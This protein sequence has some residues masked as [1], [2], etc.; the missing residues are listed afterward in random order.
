MLR[1]EVPP[2]EMKAQR[3]E[4]TFECFLEIFDTHLRYCMDFLA[5]VPENKQEPELGEWIDDRI[6]FDMYAYKEH[7]S[8]LELTEIAASKCWAIHVL[9]SGFAS[10]IGIYVKS[11]RE[12]EKIRDAIHT[13]RHTP[14]YAVKTN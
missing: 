6:Q 5:Q 2:L 9:V 3:P 8:G 11:R 4:K 7:I 1:F 12:A 10:D 14:C 13:W